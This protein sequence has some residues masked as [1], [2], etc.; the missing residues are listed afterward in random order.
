MFYKDG[1]LACFLG[2]LLVEIPL[3]ALQNT[4]QMIIVYNM[5][6]LQGNFWYL[7]LSCYG[8]AMVSNSVAMIVAAIV[9][10]MKNAA[11]MVPLAYMPQIMFAGYFIRTSQIPVFLRWVQ[12]TVGMKYCLNLVYFIEFNSNISSCQTS[13]QAKQLCQSILDSN[14][15]QGDHVFI[16]IIMLFV[17]F[18][19]FRCFA[20]FILIEKAKLF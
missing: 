6:G 4:I 1:L 19:L 16:Y 10:N 2:R 15:I 7:L 20:I 3:M 8:L 9:P 12:Y 18:V 14:D 11:E 5:M 13:L 17:L